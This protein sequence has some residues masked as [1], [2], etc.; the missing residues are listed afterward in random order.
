M[1]GHDPA[2]PGNALLVL[3]VYDESPAMAL[4]MLGYF[5][6]RNERVFRLKPVGPP[7]DSPDE[8]D[9]F[10]FEQFNK[11]AEAVGRAL[12]PYNVTQPDGVQS[13]PR[14]LVYR[15]MERIPNSTRNVT[16]QP[17]ISDGTTALMMF[18]YGPDGEAVLDRLIEQDRDLTDGVIP[19]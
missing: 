19:V 3:L 7:D 2:H 9:E 4:P 16:M 10:K 1:P 13:T 6:S 15:G 14:R 18:G 17:D 12:E 11:M 5:F 8:A